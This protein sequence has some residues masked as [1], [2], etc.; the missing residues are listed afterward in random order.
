SIVADTA[1]HLGICIAT[2]LMMFSFKNVVVGG[3]FGENGS[4]L[5]E[6]LEKEVRKNLLSN[7]D[8]SLAYY[9]FDK[10]GFTRGAALLVIMDFFT[11][12]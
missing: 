1:K 8:F 2:A 5:L 4:V 6:A 11:G 10:R 3:H 12:F 7:L 9:P